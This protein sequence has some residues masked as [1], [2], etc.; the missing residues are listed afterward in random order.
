LWADSNYY[1]NHGWRQRIDRGWEKRI[2]KDAAGLVTVSEPLRCIL[3]A[4]YSKETA[5]VWNGFDPDD[6]PPAESLS[7][8]SDGPLV[9]TYTGSLYGGRR[10]P[11]P[12]FEAIQGMGSD[13]QNVQLRFFVS[14]DCEGVLRQLAKKHAV[15]AQVQIFGLVSFE[16]SMKEQ[17]QSDVLLLLLGD[18][19][20]SEGVFTSKVFEYLG[21][22]RP[23]LVVGGNE[24]NVASRLIREREA[25]VHLNEV[26][27][28]KAQLSE[29]T[30]RKGNGELGRLDESVCLG[31]TRAE[32]VNE[33]IAFLS[34]RLEVY[35]QV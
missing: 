33:L 3:K 15:E 22:R 9:I 10:N 1:P 18:P 28:I 25:G 31:L 19:Q 30:R 20:R 14:G 17:C 4:R 23:V 5:V 32:Q 11:G 8:E 13:A 6:F 34:E 21:A 16:Q 12:L 2:L 24:K 7:Q 29:W 35:S 26:D 27:E